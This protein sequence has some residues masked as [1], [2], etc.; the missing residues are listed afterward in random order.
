[1]RPEPGDRAGRQNAEPNRAL[2]RRT[3]AGRK[4]SRTPNFL[5][6]P[7]RVLTRELLLTA[8]P[9]GAGSHPLGARGPKPSSHRSSLSAGF[10][11]AAARERPV[12]GRGVA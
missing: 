5:P 2:R 12:A 9:P 6:P 7:Q 8:E 3:L 11:R 10:G 4:P 1:M